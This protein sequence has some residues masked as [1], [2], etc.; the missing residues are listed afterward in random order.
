MKNWFRVIALVLILAATSTPA[1]SQRVGINILIPDTSAILH[2]ESD[3]L[4]FLPP[5]MT[6]INR[7]AI[8]NPATGL[9]IYNS[10]DSAVQYYNGVC[11]LSSYQ[12]NCN[13]CYFTMT[14]SSQ[15]DTIDRVVSDSTDFNLTFAQTNGN[16]QNIALAVVGILPQGITVTFTP[17][18][19][20]SSGT[21]NVVVTATPYVPAGTYPIIIQALCGS[22]TV[23]F[24][25]SVTLTPCYLIDVANSQNNY[26]VSVALYAQYPS[27]PTNQPVCVVATVF[28]GVDISSTTAAQP[29]F[30]TGALPAGSI[31]ALVN[32]GN[33]L[34][35]G[36]NG[37]TATDPA[38]GATGAGFDGGNAVN[39]TVNAVVQN[40]F[41]IYGGGGG[42]NAMAF[43]LSFQL[44]LGL[45]AIGILVGA[46]GGGGAGSGLGGNI[47][48]LFGL[49][50]YSPGTNATPTGQ[51]AT[52][53]DGGLLI[54]PITINQGP[55]S[56]SINPNAF[57]GDGGGYGY[58]G[59]TGAFQV[60]LSISLVVNIPF[61]GPVT[62]PVLTNFNIPI[63]VPIPPAGQAGNAIKRNGN[64][65]N[66]PDNNYN[67]SFLKGR[68]GN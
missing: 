55:A 35:R 42:G 28:P 27:A 26:S 37:G 4:G 13:D 34:G 57:G 29:A 15:A 1:F 6:T 22:T 51:F 68:V 10:T 63:P 60:T 14:S 49:Q 53:G 67:T 23:N 62:I 36:G 48:S 58:P 12:A 20:L 64:N 47:P 52:P 41:N 43:G 17:N 56:I 3:S 44:P 9:I 24:I 21:V 40:N 61:I 50:F 46:G 31:F 59:T 18:P 45:P 2:L 19:I 7:D 54:L 39:L 38:S 33:I 65:V 32:N 11:W 25:Y 5:V 30:T 66:I 16:P 8:A